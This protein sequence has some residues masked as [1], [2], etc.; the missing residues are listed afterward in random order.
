MKF[1]IDESGD[2]RIPENVITHKACV[3]LSIAVSDLIRKELRA[4]FERFC[5]KLNASDM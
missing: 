2:Y 3:T 5:S 1:Y 4:E